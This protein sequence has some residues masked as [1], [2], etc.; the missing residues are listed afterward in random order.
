[1][2]KKIIVT[3]AAGMVGQNLVPLLVKQ[4]YQ[5][6]ALDRNKHNLAL[7]KEGHPNIDARRVD[8]AKKGAWRNLFEHAFAVVDLKAQIASRGK[9]AFY[10]NN[11]RAEANILDACK[12]HDVPHL[13][14]ASSSVVISVAKDDYT[15][16]KKA[17]EKKVH[18]SS[19]PHTILRPTL[20]YGCFDV[21]HLGWIMGLLE[22]T[23]VLPLPGSGK[24]VRQPVY[25][26]DFCK[27]ILSCLDHGPHNKIHNI[28][29]KERI[30][31]VDL[32]KHMA[33][34]RNMKRWIVPLPVW[35]FKGM[36]NTYTLLFRKPTVTPDQLSALM[37]GDEFPV[38]P[39]WET[40][41]VSYTP[42][43]KALKEIYRS[44]CFR[45]GQR[46]QSPH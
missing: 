41:S 9:K 12:Q 31:F 28:V 37:A 44:P 36:L 38:E 23:P 45:Q 21:K 42:F 43:N 1:M 7:L 39:W 25:V 33:K 18:A 8:L 11:T 19:V 15:N 4:Q 20:M 29:G 46:M 17:C 34:A 14:H 2:R 10:R 24:Y 5:V 3:G 40:F 26:Q 32:I 35:L 16:T 22:K 30:N 6:V 27:V 13:I